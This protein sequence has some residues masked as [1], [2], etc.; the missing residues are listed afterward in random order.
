MNE[1]AYKYISDTFNIPRMA[2]LLDVMLFNNGMR[3]LT[4]DDTPA[5]RADYGI[6]VRYLDKC[7]R[8]RT[9]TG[10]GSVTF[11]GGNIPTDCSTL[12][13]GLDSDPDIDARC[14]LVK[15]FARVSLLSDAVA[16]STVPKA[17]TR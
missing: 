17:K 15:I 5:V 14:H 16:T 10:Y 4:L 13:V 11:L 6:R 9:V 7:G 8:R 2:N 12:T 1:I 3:V